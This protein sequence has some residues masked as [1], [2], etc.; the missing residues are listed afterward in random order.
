[1]M[2]KSPDDRY[3]TPLELAQA[4]EPFADVPSGSAPTSGVDVGSPAASGRGTE[5]TVT[6]VSSPPSN[7]DPASAAP[8]PVTTRARAGRPGGAPAGG[9]R[10]DPGDA[11]VDDDAV[12]GFDLGVNLGAEEPLSSGPASARP[13]PKPEPKP[14]ARPATAPARRA[15][16]C[17]ARLLG[18][19]RRGG[20]PAS[21]TPAPGDEGSLG[22]D[23][24]VNLGPER[25]RSRRPSRRRDPGRSPSPSRRPG[26][27]GPAACQAH[28]APRARRPF[29]G[30]PR[31]PD[32]GRG[33]DAGGR[34]RRAASRSGSTSA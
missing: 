13:R 23:L 24:G 5:A 26:R 16:T 19:P 21:G 6:G 7:G 27:A 9:R 33:G 10:G 2:R 8:A 4:L 15:G 1:M 18:G 31:R 34:H 29:A 20:G 25:A 14:K 17:D 32:P 28:A 30:L 12:V 3:A 11:A 22:F